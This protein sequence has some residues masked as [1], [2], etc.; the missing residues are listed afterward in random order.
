M[1]SVSISVAMSARQRDLIGWVYLVTNTVNGKK[2]IGCTQVSV[3]SR[4]QSHL[5]LAQQGSTTIFHRAIRKYGVSSFK[6][7]TLEKVNGPRRDLMAAEVRF[8]AEYGS[9]TPNGY[10]STPGGEVVLLDEAWFAA[11][12]AGCK[13]R[14]ETAWA[15]QHKAF[16]KRLHSEPKYIEARAAG[17]R[18]MASRPEWQAAHAEM[19]RKRSE[20]AV[21]REK[22]RNLVKANGLAKTARALEEDLRYPPKVRAQRVRQREIDRRAKIRAAARAR[23]EH[24]PD[25]SCVDN[26][27]W[28]ATQPSRLQAMWAASEA[29]ALAKDAL[30]SPEERAQRVKRRERCRRSR[31]RKRTGTK[32]VYLYEIRSIEILAVLDSRGEEWLRAKDVGATNG[33]YHAGVLHRLWKEGRVER[34]GSPRHYKYR[35]VQGGRQQ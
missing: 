33:S 22:A 14:G 9:M 3:K 24:V 30:C 2:Y 8:V 5:K 35:V 27:N 19:I 26:E 25:V 34:Q 15:E 29:K 21:W 17:S 6:I 31:E 11:Q 23:G 18:R 1:A 13:R 10:N 16:L 28:L 32:R 12:A 4:W 7:E 20:N